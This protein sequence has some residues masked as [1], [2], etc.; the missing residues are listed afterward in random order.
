MN[1]TIFQAEHIKHVGMYKPFLSLGDQK[2]RCLSTVI[3]DQ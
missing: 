2:V 1:Q 3:G